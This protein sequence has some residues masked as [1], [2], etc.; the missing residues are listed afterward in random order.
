M[1]R[2]VESKEAV[3]ALSTHT[4]VVDEACYEQAGVL[5]H[6]ESN[7]AA[8]AALTKHQLA[9]HLD[10]ENGVQVHSSVKRLLDRV[11]SRYRFRERHGEFSNQIENLDYAVDSYRRVK[12]FNDDKKQHYLDEIREITVEI[13][14]ALVETVSSFHR[15]VA[16]EFSMVTDVDDKIRQIGRCKREIGR[17][18]S[19]FEHLSV[20]KL[21]EW[22]QTDIH[23]ERILLKLLK[24][25]ID[26]ALKDL[27]VSNKKMVDMLAKLQRDKKSSKLNRIIDVFASKFQDD[28]TFSPSID[29]IECLPDCLSQVSE[30]EVR[31]YGNT[32]SDI[33][34]DDLI[35]LAVRALASCE[36][37]KG[38]ATDLDSIEVTDVREDEEEFELN[39][40]DE[41]LELMFEAIKSNP[42]ILPLSAAQSYTLFDLDIELEDWLLLVDGYISAQKVGLKSI[43]QVKEE[44]EVVLPYDGNV[45]I[46]DIVFETIGGAK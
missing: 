1:S 28:K 20:K 17:I 43:V 14:D 10:D 4:E 15:V 13:N 39:E 38:R 8:I 37:K 5:H 41:A 16:D 31:A 6:S 33:Q 12:D 23:L 3:R 42:N 40:V 34:A 24:S 19:I 11:T 26:I 25:K 7:K 35:D 30:T 9:Y 45:I 36:R 21:R 18:N 46:S 27:N 29:S 22:V 2:Q 44:R 32:N